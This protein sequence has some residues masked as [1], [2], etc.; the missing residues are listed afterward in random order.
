[1]SPPGALPS[2]LDS[3]ALHDALR[4]ALGSSVPSGAAIGVAAS[5]G[6]DSTGLALLLAAARP[7]LVLR[8]LHVRHGLRDDRIDA[9]R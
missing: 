9:I 6:P 5:G 8:V 4:A 7:D 3:S 2:G 1:V